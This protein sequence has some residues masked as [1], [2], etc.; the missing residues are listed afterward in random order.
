MEFNPAQ[1]SA[2]TTVS[3]PLKA[4]TSP[5]ISMELNA[6]KDAIKT[7]TGS[8][9]S[10]RDFVHTSH[11]TFNSPTPKSDPP[12]LEGCTTGQ[13]KQTPTSTRKSPKLLEVLRCIKRQYMT[14]PMF[15]EEL[16]MSDDPDVAQWTGHFHEH[17]GAERVLKIWDGKL[18]G[19]K[20]EEDFVN[21]AVNI[22]V[23]CTLKH[24]KNKKLT[25]DARKQVKD[26][27]GKFDWWVVYDNIN[28]ANK[29]HHQRADKHDTFDNGTAATLILFPSD[30]G[31]SPAAP[32]ALFRPEDERPVPTADLFFPKEADWEVPHQVSR[33]H[34][35][36]TIVRSLPKGSTAVAIPILPIQKLDIH[37]TVL[38]PLQTMRLDESTIAGNLAVLERITQ[39]GLQLP[40]TW[41]ANPKNTIF[42][43]D[44]MSVSRLLTLKIHRIVDN[45]PY[46]SLA[47]VHPTP[48]LFHLDMNLCGT[49]F[50]THYGSPQ[51]PGS[52]A[53][54]IILMD[55]K[56]LT[57]EKQE[58]KA[59]DELLRIVFDAMVLSLC[60]SLRQG[61]TSDELDIP[62]ISEIITNSFCSLPSPSLFGL[63]STTVNINAL[64]FLRDVA[65]HIE[66]TE[67]IKAGDIGR[68]S[69]LLPIITLMMH[70]GGNTNYALELLRLLYGIR[71]LWTDEWATRVLSSM[72]VNPK[73]VDGGW[74]ATDMLQE[75][76][77]YLIKSIFSSKGS[78]MTWEYL[79]DSISTNIR[80]FQVISWMFEQEVGV[81]SNSTKHQKPSPASDIV[82]IQD[83]LLAE[84]ILCKSSQC[85]RGIPVV[86]L[87]RLGGDKMI[88]GSIVRFLDRRQQ[89]SAVD[90]EEIEALENVTD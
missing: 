89:E 83:Y 88:G 53:S 77:N 14:L 29:H 69:H 45:D 56:R 24:L 37:K 11:K 50:R 51:S 85:G 68:I 80:T 84:G 4:S 65:V 5:W 2:K 78:N 48:Q 20:W 23:N 12:T 17:K 3:P 34:V 61:G 19:G 70:G 49:I 22:V 60:E 62:T 71:H 1:D 46:D 86:D 13:N 15:L 33:S 63:P 31:Q 41:F 30:K 57:K 44:Q 40:K 42:A 87:Q 90:L 54:I 26:A 10:I 64:L 28:I 75:N 7:L 55:R 59:A 9:I 52:L 25:K 16:F 79:R 72:L 43:G 73:G 81:G 8:G 36:A 6:A 39:V 38:F 32:P 82:T 47:W 35:S 58:F 21:S 76:H 67:A 66:L 18:Q 74:M 27:V